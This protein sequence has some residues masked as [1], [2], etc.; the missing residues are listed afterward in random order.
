MTTQDILEGFIVVIDSIYGVYLDS[1]QGFGLVRKR[2]DETQQSTIEKFRSSDSE[3]SSIEYLD[4]SNMLY[5]KG[6]PNDPT[7]ILL[8]KCTQAEFKAR[9]DSGGANFRFVA[10]LCLVAL[11]SILGG[12]L[13]RRN[14]QVTWIGE[15]RNPIRCNGRHSLS[16]AINHSQSRYCG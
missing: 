8:H 10:N 5:G 14:R 9:N 11:L 6:D 2:I 15:G 3:L 4:S 1:T 12:F 16:T 7:S 13:S